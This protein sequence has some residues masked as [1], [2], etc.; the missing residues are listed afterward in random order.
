MTLSDYRAMR[1]HTVFVRT[2]MATGEIVLGYEL[3]ES[4]RSLEP[5]RELEGAVADL[6]GWINDLASYA[7]ETADDGQAP[8]SLPVLLGRQHDGDLEEAFRAAS[9]MCEER[10]ATA[11]AR[12]AELTARGG[13]LAAHAGALG[14]VASSY[15]WHIR[16]SRYRT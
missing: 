2:L 14:S 7:K 1:P 16:H 12:I 4:E 11:A 5:V 8:L 10:A 13:P 3:T 6:A 15:V 9:R